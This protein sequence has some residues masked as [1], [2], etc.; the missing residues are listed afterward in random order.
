MLHISLVLALTAQKRVSRPQTAWT[1]AARGPAGP[2]AARF[3]QARR[4]QQRERGRGGGTRL[5]RN[6]HRNPRLRT[7]R[8]SLVLQSSQRYRGATGAASHKHFGTTV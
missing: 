6:V 3:A 7:Q 2:G 5:G 4:E 8:R 1:A